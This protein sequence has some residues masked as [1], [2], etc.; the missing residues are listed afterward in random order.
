MLK[1]QKDLAYEQKKKAREEEKKKMENELLEKEKA[2]LRYLY[3]N[4]ISVC[5]Q[6]ISYLEKQNKNSQQE[7][8]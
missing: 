5:N 3:A 4:E 2:K 6:L 1:L 8:E 7:E